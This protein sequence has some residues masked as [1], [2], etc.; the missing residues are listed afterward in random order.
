MGGV[1]RILGDVVDEL[2]AEV[3]EEGRVV[4]LP[5]FVVVGLSLQVNPAPFTQHS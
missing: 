3:G 2:L 5:Y 1:G 4:L